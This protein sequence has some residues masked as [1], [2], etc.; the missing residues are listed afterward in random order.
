MAVKTVQKDLFFKSFDSS[1]ILDSLP[2]YLSIQDRQ[3]NILYANQ[4]FINDFGDGIGELCHNVYKSSSFR[5]D[6]CPVLKTFDDGNIHF[7]EETVQMKNGEI[8][9]VLVQ[10]SPMK[11]EQGNITAVIEQLINITEIKK[12]QKELAVLGQSVALISHGIKNIL[13]GLQGGAY[14]VDEGVKDND[15]KLARKGWDIVKRNIFDITDVAQNILFSS[16]DRPL[17]YKKISPNRLVEESVRLFEERSLSLDIKLTCEIDQ[18]LPQI[19]V[20]P[21]SIRRMLHNLIWNAIE[22]CINDL[23]K[24]KHFVVT[25]TGVYDDR[26]IKFEVT[27]YGNDIAP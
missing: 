23:S 8:C 15:L 25:R 24:K 22:A 11:D 26:H 21:A 14:V 19:S 20:D 3:L 4:S 2:C 17:N 16:K 27:R 12:A 18:T 9:Q 6:A 5:C 10:S 7:S 1:Q 13:E